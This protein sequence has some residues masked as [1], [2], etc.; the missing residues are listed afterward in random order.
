[1]A[2]TTRIQL[3][4]RLVIE[5][6]GDRVQSRL[7]G[8]QGVRLLGYLVVN[9]DRWLTRDELVL[10]VWGEHAPPA[11]HEALASLLSKVRRVVGPE[12]VDGRGELRFI[13][14]D[15]TFVDVHCAVDAVH[16]AESR[17]A[18]GEWSRTWGPAQTAHLIGRRPL[19]LGHEAGW[20]DSWRGR[21]TDVAVRGLECHVGAL[22]AVGSG[23]CDEIVRMA[24][25]LVELAPFRESGHR[26]LM[27]AFESAG[28]PAEALRAYDRLRCLLVDEL[29][30]APGPDVATVHA[31]LLRGS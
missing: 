26:L 13:Q 6:D 19:L 30:V 23:R 10:A 4:G 28:N 22:L 27:E 2:W 5:R 11:S 25:Q 14:R 8:R 24:R 1:M 15:E 31:R 16:R 9:A 29:G 7:P 12:H 17:L 21:L 20:I 18:A 3:C